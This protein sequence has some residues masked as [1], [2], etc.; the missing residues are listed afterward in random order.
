MNR[1]NVILAAIAGAAPV[2]AAVAGRSDAWHIGTKLALN[3]LFDSGGERDNLDEM[4]LKNDCRNG[5]PQINVAWYYLR[6][7]REINDDR[8]DAAFGAVL[9][10]FCGLYADGLNFARFERDAATPVA[11]VCAREIKA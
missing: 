5:Q 6:K 7:L 4:A 11:M 3:M 2:S 8:V 10:E 1:R 9:S